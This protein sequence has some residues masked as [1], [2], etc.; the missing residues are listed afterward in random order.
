M[1]FFHLEM[2]YWHAFA[3]EFYSEFKPIRQFHIHIIYDIGYMNHSA[4]TLLAQRTNI[5]TSSRSI[6]YCTI[7]VRISISSNVIDASSLE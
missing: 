6:G 4:F 3:A 1:H 7:L 2:Y 5:P